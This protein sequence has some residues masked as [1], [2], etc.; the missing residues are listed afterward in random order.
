MKL[1]SLSQIACLSLHCLVETP[2]DDEMF[3]HWV[4]VVGFAAM[5]E[6]K[7]TNYLFSFLSLV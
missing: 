1:F 6:Q 7:R 3:V 4:G 2:G 5:M